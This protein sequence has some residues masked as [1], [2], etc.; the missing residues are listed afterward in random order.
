M[1][2]AGVDAE[3]AVMPL[4]HLLRFLGGEFALFREEL[5]H[6][7]ANQFGDPFPIPSMQGV[8]G[9]RADEGAVG[10]EDMQMRVVV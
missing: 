9:M 8:E 6:P 1:A 3:S 4:P 7:D 2:V 10:N 5:E